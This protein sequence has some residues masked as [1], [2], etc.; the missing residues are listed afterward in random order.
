M[1]NDSIIYDDIP[2]RKA[3]SIR[4]YSEMDTR[5]ALF[6]IRLKYWYTTFL[7]M[8]IMGFMLMIGAIATPRWS[9]QGVGQ[10]K[11]R[12]GILICG[13]CT[14]YWENSYISGIVKDTD[15]YNISGYKQ[16]FTNLLN[17]GYL[18]VILETFS[19]VMV[20]IWI[21]QI[22]ALMLRKRLLRDKFF[23]IVLALLVFFH[24]IAVAGWFGFTNA[25]F[26]GSCNKLS[27]Y[28]NSYPICPTHGPTISIFIEIY[29]SLVA[30]GF[31]YIFI[32]RNKAIVKDKFVIK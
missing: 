1:D 10:Y 11:W 2:E 26:T 7:I 19:L 3:S 8:V 22:I 28:Q 13:G 20:C 6:F 21:A 23:I 31:C 17:G 24:T 16:T 29:I 5:K 15:N 27:D 14:G 30:I 32:N 25:S 9:E 18:Y 12:S 4:E